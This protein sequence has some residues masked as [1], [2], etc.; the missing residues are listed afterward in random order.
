MIIKKSNK[1]QRR[2]SKLRS[3][4]SSSSKTY[5]TLFAYNY[6]RGK[7]TVKSVRCIR[8]VIHILL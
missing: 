1:L 8:C 3:S 5:A 2:K 7:Q 6:E 4:S